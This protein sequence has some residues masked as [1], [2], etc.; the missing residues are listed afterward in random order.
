VIPAFNEEARVAGVIRA[1]HVAVPALDVLVV[2]DG[3]VDETAAVARGAGAIVVRL[4]V[5]LGYGGAAQTGYKFALR[6]GYDCVVQL[7][8]D[9]QHEP[10][11]IPSLLGVVA[12]R[13]ADIAL[14]SR[15]MG[16]GVYRAG[17]ARRL[18]MALFR[19]LAYLTSG[20]RILDVTSGFQALGHDVIRFYASEWYPTDYAD[21]D[22]LVTLRRAGFTLKEVPVRMYPRGGGRSMHAGLVRPA[23]YVF[24]MLFA[25]ALAPFRNESVR[26]RP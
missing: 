8:A 26:R 6:E 16:A 23:Y 11:D 20:V 18:G 3:S 10:A 21:A 7:D 24:K 12:R 2:D 4:P 19:L 9:G 5:N 13:E 15:F 22:V 14:G 17:A 1:V 25:V